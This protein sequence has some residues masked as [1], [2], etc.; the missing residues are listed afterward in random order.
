M[1]QELDCFAVVWSSRRDVAECQCGLA[2][3][4]SVPVTNCAACGRLGCNRSASQLL[5]YF[6][7]SQYQYGICQTPNRYFPPPHLLLCLDAFT[8]ARCCRA[9]RWPMT[10]PEIKPGLVTTGT[11]TPG[12]HQS[13]A[14]AA[15]PQRN[16]FPLDSSVLFCCRLDQ[17]VPGLRSPHFR[18]YPVCGNCY[19]DWHL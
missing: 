4:F 12:V 6:P 1:L 14:G 19:E 16:I 2:F 8:G 17:V 11:N 13:G 5:L 15:W 7:P 9:T 3:V 18:N 10:I